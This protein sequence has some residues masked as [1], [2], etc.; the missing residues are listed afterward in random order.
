MSRGAYILRRLLL[1]IPIALGVTLVTFFMI[2]LIPGDPA[3]TLLG[4]KASP[5]RVALLHREWGLDKPL[6]VQYWLF[7]ERIVRGNFGISLFYDSPATG[8]ILGDSL[9]T[10]WLITYSIVLA[11]VIAI[12]LAIVAATHRDRVVDQGVRAIP[13]VGMGMPTAWLSIMLILVFALKAHAFPV[14]GYGSGF[15][16]HLHSMFLPSLALALGIAPVLI[17]SLRS[18]LIDSF[19]ADYVATARSKGISERRVLVRHAVRNAIIVSVTIL[20][21]EIAWLIGGTIIVETVF[22]LPGIGAL[23]VSSIYRRDFPVVQGITF[24]LAL[25]VILTNLAT[26]VCHSLLDPRVR[27]D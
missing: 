12:P 19:D 11:V 21:L 13:L 6:Y 7:L 18:S 14:G 10:L 23:M 20:G 17:R 8:I 3:V 9:V 25:A 2:H 5:A 27:F 22:A 1:M 4:S 24:I 16:G 15:T 26:D